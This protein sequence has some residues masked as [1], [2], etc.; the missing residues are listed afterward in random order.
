MKATT[1]EYY[2]GTNLKPWSASNAIQESV[3]LCWAQDRSV[4]PL[5]AK[6]LA[7]PLKATCVGLRNFAKGIIKF[8][9]QF[10]PHD[11]L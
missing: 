7:S 6:E 11:P 3:N 5:P 1:R 4:P 9:Q 8:A 2:A 10:K